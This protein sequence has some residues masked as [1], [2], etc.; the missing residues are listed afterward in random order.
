MKVQVYLCIDVTIPN[1]VYM[2]F[3]KKKEY[4]VYVVVHHYCQIPKAGLKM[5]EII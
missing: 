2:S 5:E 1:E 3:D 4:K